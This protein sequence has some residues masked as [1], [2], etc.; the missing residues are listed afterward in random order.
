MKKTSQRAAEERQD[1][2]KHCDHRD[3]TKVSLSVV[4]PPLED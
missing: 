1:G 4:L 3:L 2:Q